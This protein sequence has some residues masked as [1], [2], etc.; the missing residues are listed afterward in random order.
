M[1]NNRVA[2]TLHCC[3]GL[4]CFRSGLYAGSASAPAHAVAS[5]LWAT[6]A[7]LGIRSCGVRSK[8]VVAPDSSARPLIQT[9]LNSNS[10]MVPFEFKLTSFY[11]RSCLGLKWRQNGWTLALPWFNNFCRNRHCRKWQAIS[12]KTQLFYCSL[13]GLI[14]RCT[15]KEIIGCPA[16][17]CKLTF[18][19]SLKCYISKETFRRLNFFSALEIRKS[20]TSCH[21]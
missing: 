6:V 21:Y 13:L 5:F 15:G 20:F 11:C 4:F 14:A 10:F 17:P 12:A 7:G 18:N 16:P 1:K 9:P 3:D 2:H 8:R 19:C